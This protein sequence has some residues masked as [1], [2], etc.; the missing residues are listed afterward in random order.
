MTSFRQM[1]ANRGNALRSTGP[2]AE[3]GKRRSGEMYACGEDH[4]RG[5]ARMSRR[6]DQ[7]Y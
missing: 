2:K 4:G 3:A 7:V 6:L 5:P 1:E